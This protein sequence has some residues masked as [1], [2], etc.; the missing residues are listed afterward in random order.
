MG[1]YYFNKEGVSLSNFE[2]LA[3]ENNNII[4]KYYKDQPRSVFDFYNSLVK[5]T[6]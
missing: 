3:I 2:K 1:N 6:H 5:K 4:T